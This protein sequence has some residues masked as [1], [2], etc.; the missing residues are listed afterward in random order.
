MRASAFMDPEW[1]FQDPKAFCYKIPN[2]KEYRKGYRKEYRKD[3]RKEQPAEYRRIQ[4]KHTGAS[5]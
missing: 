3:F 4:K 1:N 5:K 2:E